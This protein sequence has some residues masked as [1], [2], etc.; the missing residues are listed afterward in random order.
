MNLKRKLIVWFIVVAVVA[1]V[2][3]TILGL[4]SVEKQ[5]TQRIDAKLSGTVDAA[6]SELNGW[7]ESNTKVV[8]TIGTVIQD[9][10]PKEQVKNTHLQAFQ[11]DSNSQNISALFVGYED[12]TFI[13]GSGWVPE[14]GYDARTRPWYAEVKKSG[15]LSYSDPYLEKVTNSSTVSISVPLL[16]KNGGFEGVI[17]GE[18][19]LSTIT[20]TIKKVKLDGDGY[21]F[22]I[23]KN[24]TILSHPDDKL[25]NKK[26]LDDANLKPLVVD[27]LA[28]ESGKKEYVVQN[29]ERLM[30]YK[31]IPSTDW[32]VAASVSKDAA[33]KEFYSLRNQ[34][35]LMSIGT[36]IIVAFLAFMI[37]TRMVKPLVRL[38][39][40][41]QKMSQ[42]DLTAHVAVKGRD[43]IA[44]LGH[45]F[46]AMSDNLRGLIQK[47]ADSAVIVDS[48]SQNVYN[49]AENT[50]RIAEQISTAVEE[51]ANGS[52][53]QAQSV[54]SGSEMVAGMTESVHSISQ[55]VEQTVH[56]IDEANH[57][58]K[59]GVEI[60]VNQVDLAKESRDTTIRVGESIELLAEKSQK[61][62]EIVGVIHN[63]AE[64]TNLLSLNAAIEAARAGEHGK[65]FSVVA[66]EV[67]KLAEQSAVSSESIIALIK[68]IQYASKKSVSEVATAIDVA[69]KQ[70]AAVN[71][72]KAS[73]DK[74]EQSV[75][76]IVVQIQEVS[77]AAEDLH[78]NA[79]NISEVISNVAAVAE[80]SAASTE[81]VAAST[82]EQATSVMKISEL[83][84]DLTQNADVLLKEVQKF[85][86]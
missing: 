64:Q 53:E 81:E 83:S 14:S 46:N 43:E 73:F 65:G 3:I 31:K 86:I 12:G 7:I 18:V 71:E 27:M 77:S 68:E 59:N 11:R 79:S 36:L 45:S 37:A 25:F 6:A 62:E 49:H 82:Q 60:V 47:V 24:S 32:V 75:E 28:S 1:I 80:E 50:G 35:V 5:A 17:A 41:S 84:E 29:E 9:A 44:D 21:A 15:K 8:E 26:M 10:V 48:T 38:K 13:D 66:E 85:K 63:I 23:D 56:M 30:M 40:T 57:A 72:T 78:M 70:E 58:M 51:L 69:Q 52:A 76:G 54:H 74:I 67:R 16:N 33:Y 4:K 61:I 39:E 22:L 34:Y 19:N 20:D 55:N 42:G 2:P